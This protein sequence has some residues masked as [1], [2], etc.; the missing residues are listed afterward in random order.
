MILTFYSFKGGVGRTLALANIGVALARDH[1]VLAIDF[2]L[3]AP[4]LSRYYQNA[5]DRGDLRD[6]SGLLD[7]LQ[8][9]MREEGTFDWRDYVTALVG[10]TR[11]RLDVITSGRQDDRYAAGVLEFRWK[12]FFD[13]YHGGATME[14]LRAE[15]DD[16]YDF[17]LIDSRTGITDAGGICTI[18][19]PDVL[20]P[21]FTANEQSLYGIVDVM[22]RAQQGRTKLA[23][24]PGPALVFPLPSR[25][26]DRT[27]IKLGE[28]WLDRFAKELGEFYEPWLPTDYEPRD[29]LA[30]TKLPYVSYYSFG[31]ELPVVRDQRSDVTSLGFALRS[32]ATLIESHF[33]GEAV[34]HL[35]GRGPSGMSEPVEGTGA[36]AEAWRRV[37]RGSQGEGRALAVLT[38]LAFMPE[39]EPVPID[40]L[41]DE[42]AIGEL[43][44]EGLIQVRGREALLADRSL[45]AV[46]RPLADELQARAE[47]LAWAAALRE[48]VSTRIDYVLTGPE[49][50]EGLSWYGTAG[51]ALTTFER[52]LVEDSLA[53]RRT[54]RAAGHVSRETWVVA[55]VI[56]VAV[57]WP[58]YVMLGSV[59]WYFRPGVVLTM[60]LAIGLAFAGAFVGWLLLMARR[61]VTAV[62]DSIPLDTSW[63]GRRR[64]GRFLSDLGY[65]GNAIGDVL[66]FNVTDRRQLFADPLRRLLGSSLETQDLEVLARPDH[67]G[68][69]TLL[70]GPRFVVWQVKDRAVR[71]SEAS[72]SREER[73][74]RGSRPTPR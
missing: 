17:V 56:A 41:G 3:E 71:Q 7:L 11:G 67:D 69:G 30:R 48:K 61:L 21:M 40:L 26:D 15:W 49:L 33:G 65:E 51:N 14:T 60:A 52:A 66:V 37:T 54:R 72:T 1:S 29:I 64:L 18:Q 39:L 45:V 62:E 34:D 47:L 5:F 24:K 16:A 53:R 8:A 27:E 35:L 36:V 57:G 70:E 20:V 43:A 59:L 50:A 42:E 23:R 68:R 55:G 12:H 4:G 31:E 22:R 28:E 73:I 44:K 38:R 25:F 6:Q 63:T 74:S 46:L 13:R 58:A 32:A 9:A 2:D 10:G 19:L